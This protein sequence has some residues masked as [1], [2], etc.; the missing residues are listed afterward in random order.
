MSR[1]FTPDHDPSAKAI[2]ELAQELRNQRRDRLREQYRDVHPSEWP[3]EHPDWG[4]SQ[5]E[6]WGGPKWVA[7]SVRRTNVQEVI[8]AAQ[9][10]AREQGR[11]MQKALG[12][13][14]KSPAAPVERRK[15]GRPRRTQEGFHRDYRQARHHC[16]PDAT[17]KELANEIGVSE[18]WFSVLVGRFGRPG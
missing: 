16:G 7:P 4:S 5:Y 3:V 9:G 11:R 14:P 15:A 17:D 6:P 12:L 8:D 13:E 2:R 10:V 18:Q 1:S